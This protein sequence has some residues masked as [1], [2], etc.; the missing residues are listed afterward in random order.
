[1]RFGSIVT[2]LQSAARSA[3][4]GLGDLVFP[5]SCTFCGLDLAGECL[6][7][8]LC[9][10]CRSKLAASSGYRC[11]KCAAR[12]AETFQDGDCP[13]CRSHDLRFDRTFTLGTYDGELRE[14][15]LRTKRPG[16]DALTAAL[17]DLLWDRFA[18]EMAAAQLDVVLPVPMH[19]SR[20]LRRGYSGP[21]LAAMLL[22]K[23]LRLPDRPRG[24]KR[25]RVTK[26]QA[27]LSVPQRRENVR[28]AFA[29]R[30]K[31]QVSG[32][33]VLLVDDILTSGATCS[34]AARILKRA[35]AASVVVAVIARAQGET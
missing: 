15:A 33:R 11:P 7:E 6:K 8:P 24:L 23:R 31:S 29:V 21:E 1:M 18:A 14:A 5:P 26:P 22:A 13:W 28:N 16:G 12:V 25:S 27:G 4:H 19:W 10:E 20:R 35:G 32:K 34:E 9:N 17:V 2:R 3:I 30:R